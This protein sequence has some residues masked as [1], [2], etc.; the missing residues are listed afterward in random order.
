MKS[1]SLTELNHRS[2]EVI[3]AAHNGPVEITKRGKRRYVILT[4]E[5]YDRLTNRTPTRRVVHVDGLGE[6]E[7]DF[8]LNA[9]ARADEED[10]KTDR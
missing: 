9:L 5:R 10:G 2:G 3:E 7:A 6:E 8:Y 1:Y 4:A